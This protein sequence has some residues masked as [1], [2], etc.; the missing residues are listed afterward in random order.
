MP[1][2]S[3]ITPTQVHNAD[4]LGHT[5]A[6]VLGQPL[7]PGWELEWLVQE[8]G[9]APGARE[10]L[11]DDDRVRY[12]ALGLQLGGAAA[13]NAALARSRGD[14]VAGIDHDDRYTEE[15]LRALV[16]A[17]CGRPAAQWACGR[18]R[19]L[20]PDGGT[21]EKDD[22]LPAGPVDPGTIA[23][24]YAD[25]DD[26]PFPAAFTLYRRDPL[27]AVG[28]WPA[29]VRSTDAVLLSAFS[30]DHPGVWVAEIV[31]EYRRWDGQYT[32]QDADLAVRDLPH[33]RDWMRQR[34]RAQTGR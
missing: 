19:W 5:A 22:V 2:V 15:G 32:V 28:G 7:P 27:V 16:E 23:A 1:L 13:R 24:Y 12:E 29:V 31:A 34:F 25:T 3:V 18:C 10:L 26:W 17:L 30:T 21:W 11:P 4:W 9:P 6:S 8:D 14:L 33:V 20:L